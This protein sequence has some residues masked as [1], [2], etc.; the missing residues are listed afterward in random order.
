MNALIVA[1]ANALVADVHVGAFFPDSDRSWGDRA[2]RL[3][4]RIGVG[5]GEVRYDPAWG[6]GLRWEPFDGI[7]FGAG[8]RRLAAELA[9]GGPEFRQ[10]HETLVEAAVVDIRLVHRVD[11]VFIGVEAAPGMWRT[12]VRAHGFLGEG[13]AS[14]TVGGL[15]LTGVCGVAVGPV[16]L[17]LRLG[18]DWFDLPAVP[19]TYYAVGGPGGGFLLGI[20]F[21]VRHVFGGDAAR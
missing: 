7:E 14:K 12:D 3:Y 16:E 10:V 17:S 11:S 9:A 19:A 15:D 2:G 1:L 13:H 21:G 8:Y 20:G 18:H 4:D 6:I 5:R